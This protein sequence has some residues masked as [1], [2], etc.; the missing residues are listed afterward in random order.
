MKKMPK[1]TNVT[2]NSVMTALNSRRMR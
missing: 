1:V 2:T